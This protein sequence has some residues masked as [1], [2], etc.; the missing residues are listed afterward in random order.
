MMTRKANGNIQD[1]D[2]NTPLHYAVIHQ[3]YSVIDKLIQNYSHYR[4]V[5]KT[6]KNNAGQTAYYTC[7]KLKRP[8][9][10]C[11]KLYVEPEPV[12]ETSRDNDARYRTHLIKR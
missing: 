1:N 6:I 11:K 9:N 8:E 10:V 7:L 4:G 3:K 5:D 12:T 2:G